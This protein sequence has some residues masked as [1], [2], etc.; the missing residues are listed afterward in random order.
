MQNIDIYAKK[1]LACERKDIELVCA[2]N[3]L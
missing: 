1:V 3:M 2:L